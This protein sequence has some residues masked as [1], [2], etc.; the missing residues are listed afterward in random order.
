MNGVSFLSD[1]QDAVKA[2][3]MKIPWAQTVRLYPDI[4]ADFPTPAIFFDVAGWQRADTELGGNVT[5]E[6][7]CNLFV[8]RHFSVGDPDGTGESADNRVRNAAL[9]LS[10][11]VH[12]RQFG[13]CTAPAE[14]ISA[15]PVV[16]QKSEG[17]AD[18]AIWNVSFSQRLAVGADPF[19][20]PDAPRLKEFWLG[21]FP[22][23]GA[24]H[25]QDYTLIAKE[26]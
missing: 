4:P 11:W 8:L 18:H 7:R 5:L 16:W 22:D 24:G 6:L 13:S 10:D 9:K 15:E 12:G 20:E 25:E 2:A 21:I 19:D 1:Y 14:F 3:L 23:V 17:G 26:E